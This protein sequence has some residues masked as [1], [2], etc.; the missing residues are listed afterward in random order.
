MCHA[1]K[2]YYMFEK[3]DKYIKEVI[4]PLLPNS[5][6]SQISFFTE[7]DFRLDLYSPE[8]FRG[9]LFDYPFEDDLEFIH[10]TSICNLFNIIRSKS[11]WMKDLN[12]LKDKSEFI[13]ANSYLDNKKS[14]KLKSK[15]LSLSLCRFSE[16]TLL[17]KFM[18]H[19]Y[20]DKDN[21]ICIKL[22]FHKNRGIPPFFYLGRINY[23]NEVSPIN[24]LIDLRNRHDRFRTENKFTISNLDE[25]LFSVSAMFKK[26]CYLEEEEIRLM[27]YILD[28]NEPYKGDSKCQIE[29]LYDSEKKK[30]TYFMELPINN[31]NDNYI[32]P[33]ISVEEIY[34]GSKISQMEFNQLSN[35]I[36]EKYSAQFN[37][38]KKINIYKL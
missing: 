8:I 9:S 7:N 37:G 5:K 32:A 11:I 27:R 25:I 30:Y 14:E 38:S 21:G 31:S 33:H 13:F 17:N 22:K 24:E 6:Q 20:A 10:F 34:F 4:E 12:S 26:E 29:Y 3:G 19:N 15:I 16:K 2:K 1:K 28:L 36:H 18:W 35:L 23:K